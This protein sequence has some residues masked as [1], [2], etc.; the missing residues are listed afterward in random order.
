[1]SDEVTFSSFTVNVSQFWK[2]YWKK[3]YKLERGNATNRGVTVSFTDNYHLWHLNNGSAESH[4]GLTAA[5]AKEQSSHSSGNP[6]PATAR[7]PRRL[8]SP[9]SRQ[10]L[11]MRSWDRLC[12]VGGH[13]PP[14]LWGSLGVIDRSKCQG[15]PGPESGDG[16]STQHQPLEGSILCVHR[17]VHMFCQS[18]ASLTCRRG[19]TG[20]G[21]LCLWWST[22]DG[23]FLSVPICVDS[24]IYRYTYICMYAFCVCAYWEHMLSLAARWTWGL[25][26]TAS[27][28]TSDYQI[29]EC[30]SDP[31]IS[32]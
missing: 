32:M 27:S 26:A 13:C 4:W 11:R 14:G 16:V 6:A 8:S 31:I 24:Y 12:P 29:Q 1:M 9:W 15:N 19:W 17:H 23:C 20:L 22:S 3:L 28:C 21:H 5:N 2:V 7:C 18:T 10:T 25:G 30:L